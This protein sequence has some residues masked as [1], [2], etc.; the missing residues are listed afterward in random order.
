[1]PHRS[2]EYKAVV[3]QLRAPTSTPSMAAT[4]SLFRRRPHEQRHAPIPIRFNRTARYLAWRG[5]MEPEGV[6]T[7]NLIRAR[8]R[9]RLS[10][11]SIKEVLKTLWAFRLLGWC[12]GDTNYLDWS[13]VADIV[14]REC[15]RP[16][17][18]IDLMPAHFVRRHRP[19]DI[20]AFRAGT[21][22]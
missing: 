4:F 8:D 5:A 13:E 10:A 19:D 11:S 18:T 16:L 15:P 9:H 14:T 21:D 2:P 7:E 20:T 22:S 3:D 1:M 17:D 12:P 6:S